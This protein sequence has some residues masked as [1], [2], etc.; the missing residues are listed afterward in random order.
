MLSVDKRL[1]I[2]RAVAAR[3]LGGMCF[4]LCLRIV[5]SYSTIGFICVLFSISLLVALLLI[6]KKGWIAAWRERV[7]TFIGPLPTQ[8]TSSQRVACVL[9]FLA[10]P[11]LVVLLDLGAFSH[12]MRNADSKAVVHAWFGLYSNALVGVL[13]AACVWRRGAALW[14]AIYCS[15]LFFSPSS[16]DVLA[17]WRLFQNGNP[18]AALLW[19]LV[20]VSPAVAFA[21]LF[22]GVFET[23]KHTVRAANGPTP[24]LDGGA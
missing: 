2:M 20:E 13:W 16:D 12:E 19:M 9:T 5:A 4:L 18:I 14:V 23:A 24:S 7:E 22:G 10:L 21:A 3:L 1:E 15:S 11:V 17:N 6:P 8:P